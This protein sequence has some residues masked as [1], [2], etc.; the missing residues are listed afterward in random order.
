MCGRKYNLPLQDWATYREMLELG[1][2][3][4]PDFTQPNY[5]IAPSHEVPVVAFHD[6]ERKMRLMRWGL[7]PFWAKDK[8][9]GYKMINARAE[10]VE[11]KKSFSPCLKAR[12]CVIPVSGFYEWKRASKTDKQAYA[13]RR[14]D[15]RP[16]LLAGLW[17]YNTKIDEAGIHSY[18][19]LTHEPNAVVADIHNR[20]PVILD[21]EE[22]MTWLEAPWAEAREI[23][24]APFA[25]QRMEAFPVSNDVGKVSNNY[26]ELVN[27]ISV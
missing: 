8:S 18:T 25:S 13:I 15:D 6:G 26:P 22:I 24:A 16:L 17:S 21:E 5:N 2:D 9:I 3:F 7:L 14:T 12:R 23:T 20:M 10:T 4:P 19:V 27:K 11:E 1:Y